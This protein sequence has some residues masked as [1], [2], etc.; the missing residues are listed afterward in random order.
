M[1][2]GSKV[3]SEES[4]G[5]RISR[6]FL[7]PAIEC[8]LGGNNTTFK[9]FTVTRADWLNV[10]NALDNT[11]TTNDY[12]GVSIVQTVRRRR[13]ERSFKS[14]IP[15]QWCRS[16]NLLAHYSQHNVGTLTT[17]WSHGAIGGGVALCD[18]WYGIN[19]A[20]IP[21]MAF[22]SLPSTGHLPPMA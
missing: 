16:D 17:V 9:N 1:K 4:L 14:G 5:L 2:T 10:S 18:A 12:D 11:I 22:A 6:M 7:F 13:Y 8:G 21:C 19:G 20:R 15:A 3:P